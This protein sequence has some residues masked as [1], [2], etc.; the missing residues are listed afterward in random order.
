MT[1]RF[2][3]IEGGEG[4]GK[5]SLVATLKSR[6]PY[7]Y[8]FTREPGGTDAAEELRNTI[9]AK[10]AAPL[11]VLTQILL[12]AAARREHMQKV[13]LPAL[14]RGQHVICDRFSASTYAYQVVAGA[15]AAYKD[16]F[17]IV[18]DL[19][20]AGTEPGLWVFL[21]IEPAIGLARKSSSGDVLNAFDEKDL[22]F[23]EAVRRGMKEYLAPR[24]HVVIDASK[25]KEEVLKE[26]MTSVS[27]L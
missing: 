27:A 24:R 13:V 18:D 2:V 3:V 9:V 1:G 23:H 10:R 7:T 11:D 5:S 26:V 12:F 14:A 25:S 8:V 17:N 6:L 19:V 21:D 20:R 4:A 22:A 15:G 16:F